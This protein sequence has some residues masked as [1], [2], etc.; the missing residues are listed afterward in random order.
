MLTKLSHWFTSKHL[1]MLAK[2]K[3]V[4]ELEVGDWFIKWGLGWTNLDFCFKFRLCLQ[5]IDNRD[6]KHFHGM[7]GKLN[8]YPNHNMEN[9]SSDYTR[10][11]WISAVSSSFPS[12]L[13]V[14]LLKVKAWKIQVQQKYDIS[15]YRFLKAFTR[16]QISNLK[17]LANY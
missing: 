10:K 3:S 14:F 8:F 9:L 6:I 4:N 11:I 12:Y 5:F 1:F 7:W 13:N 16:I 17:H 2:F 15:I